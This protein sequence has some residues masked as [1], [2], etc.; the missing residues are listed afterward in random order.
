[1][2]HIV[3]L[4]LIALLSGGD[5]S[6]SGSTP[7]TNPNFRVDRLFEVD[8]C[9]VYRFYDGTYRYFTSCQGSIGSAEKHGD[10]YIPT[11]VIDTTGNKLR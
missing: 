7:T 3:A 4:L 11:S 6:K 8:G 1:M 10:N 9:T 2:K 5:N